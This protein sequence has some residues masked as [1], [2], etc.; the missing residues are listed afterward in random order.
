VQPIVVRPARGYA[1]TFEIIAGERRWRAAQ[2][3]GLHQQRATPAAVAGA[4]QGLHQ[5]GAPLLLVLAGRF[6]S[7]RNVCLRDLGRLC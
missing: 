4:G 5:C 7:E 3:A 6:T 2:R 1:D